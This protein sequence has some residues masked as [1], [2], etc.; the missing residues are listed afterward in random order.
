MSIF[1]GAISSFAGFTS[2]HTLSA[3]NHA[4][5]S[6]SEQAEI[7][8]TQTK[9]GTGSSTPTSGMLLRGTG[10]GTSSWAQAGLT[11]DVTGVLPQANGGT[12]TTLATGTGKAVYDTSPTILTPTIASF[13]N[14]AHDHTNAAGGGSLGTAT[15]GSSQIVNNSIAFTD[16]LSTIFSGQL[17]TQVNA[18][19][20]GGNLYWINLG[21]IKI[22]WGIGASQAVGTGGATFTFTLPAFF[23]TI[24]VAMPTMGVIT[25]SGRQSTTLNSTPTTSNI[26]W[27]GISDTNGSS[28]VPQ[29]LIIGT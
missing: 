25:V 26:D 21:G 7:V 2:S 18:G 11:T 28:V 22:M 27:N 23:T 20:A 12:G 15:V 16:L 29:V 6:N 5:Q 4:S 17:A 1:P 3:D 13:T 8:A 9:I 10:A 24:T 14:A 19:T